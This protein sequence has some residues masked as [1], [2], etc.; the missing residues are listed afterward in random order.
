MNGDFKNFFTS[1]RMTLN[2]GYEAQSQIAKG[3]LLKDTA[4]PSS[5]LP[6]IEVAMAYE[7]LHPGTL[8]KTLQLAHNEQRHRHEAANA[9]TSNT[10]KIRIAGQV[11]ALLSTAAL[12][13]TS[14]KI[15][16]LGHV[17]LSAL[18]MLGYVGAV[19]LLAAVQ[20]RSRSHTSQSHE[21]HYK[22]VEQKRH[23]RP[24]RE[25]RGPQ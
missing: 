14:V 12:C 11:C 22:R 10:L 17:Y 13:L 9:L 21:Q 16:S 18:L 6:P 24:F 1:G 15:A 20:W 23:N 2:K 7:E 3:S 4:S 5:L 8:E 19:T 25:R